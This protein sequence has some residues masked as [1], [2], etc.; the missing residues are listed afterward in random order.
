MTDDE[1]KQRCE[2]R[3][4]VRISFECEISGYHADGDPIVALAYVAM[5]I[6][7][8]AMPPQDVHNVKL[9]QIDEYDNKTS[10]DGQEENQ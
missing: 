8:F 7:H 10:E 3:Q 6:G 1:Y 9:E 5:K 4:K 2:R